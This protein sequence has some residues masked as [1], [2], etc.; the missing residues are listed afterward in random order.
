MLAGAG[1]GWS[2][3]DG[4]MVEVALKAV[5]EAEIRLGSCCPT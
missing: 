5:E 1:V 2:V 3:G 4:L